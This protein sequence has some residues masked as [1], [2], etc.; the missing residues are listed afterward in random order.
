MSLSL[1]WLIL[2]L[3]GPAP[4]AA[5]ATS[6]PAPAPA[7]AAPV[8]TP[9]ARAEQAAA[10]YQ[11]RKY[12]EAAQILEDLWASV[13]E[14]RDLFNAGLA[15]LALG[16]RAH[17]IG[18]WELYLKQPSIPQDG[19]EQALDRIK[20]AQAASTGIIVRTA[21][22]ALSEL[23][24]SLVLS[25]V[26]G[27]KR[28]DLTFE[29]PPQAPEFASGGKT[30]YLDPGKW[31]LKVSARTYVT[32]T[33]DILLKPGGSGFVLDV[34]LAS[35]PA[36]RFVT[37]Q[38]DPVDAVSAGAEVSLQKLA[39][40]AQP[41]PCPLDRVGKCHARVEPGD[42]EVTVQAPG[43]QRHV[44]KLSL[45]AEPMSNLA[46]ALAPA[47]ALAPVPVPVEPAPPAATPAEG[48]EPAPAAPER[49][50]KKTR[51][52]LSAGLITAGIPVFI[53][54]LA[55]AVHGSN[56]YDEKKLTKEVNGDLLPAIRLRSAGTGLMGAAVGLF[57]TG[58]TAEYDVKPWVWLTE[59]GIGAAALIGGSTWVAVSTLRW[60]N[61]DLQRLV[62]N[63][64]TGVDC[65]TA[66]RLGAG[67]FLGLGTSLVVGAT[68]GLVVQ[69]R[70]TR[71][72]PPL[73]LSPSFGAGHGG[74][75]LQGRF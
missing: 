72:P 15:R 21:P 69:R 31:Q 3:V 9:E 30:L 36:F 20:K 18:Y 32:S 52:R 35:D 16:H 54:G 6:A 12:L 22:S 55:V 75:V 38:V 58:L 1:S 61:D 43:Y 24:V 23:G 60:N 53:T 13:H 66:H 41:V 26:D 56:V 65:F 63:N 68:T 59:L 49:V 14:P 64:N 34:T 27:D 11:Q 51:L 74:L 10:L 4:A 71:K 25:R 7:T 39:L 73:S 45:G 28:P 70:H 48:P 46:V 57:T 5:A 62:C 8:A 44:E 29:L 47:A 67:F 42:W 33:R 2:T 19:R 50:P 40:G 37:V 17:A